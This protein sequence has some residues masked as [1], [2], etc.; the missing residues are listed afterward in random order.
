VIILVGPSQ[1]LPKNFVGLAESPGAE[2]GAN[3]N[4]A[5]IQHP[6]APHATSKSASDAKI[7][8]GSVI[9]WRG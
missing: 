7:S 8:A 5:L 2:P 6:V 4:A 1:C 3:E 9:N